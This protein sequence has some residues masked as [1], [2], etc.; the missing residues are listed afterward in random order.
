[1]LKLLTSEGPSLPCQELAEFRVCAESLARENRDLDRQMKVAIA[2]S[3]RLSHEHTAVVR[4]RDEWN[5]G[6]QYNTEFNSSLRKTV[7]TQEMQ[8]REL[9]RQANRRVIQLRDTDLER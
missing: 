1:M 6:A 4:E 3:A 8:L 9:T 2:K 5:G 7:C